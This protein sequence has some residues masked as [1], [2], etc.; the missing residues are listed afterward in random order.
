[1]CG[2][3]SLR[4]AVAGSSSR[5]CTASACTCQAPTGSSSTDGPLGS[6]TW[7]PEARNAGSHS[8]RWR[9]TSRAVHSGTGAGTSHSCVPRT[10]S[11]NTPAS[12]AWRSAGRSEMAIE[13]HPL[14]FGV[15]LV[16]ADFHAGPQPCV[17]ALEAVDQRLRAQPA[18]AAAQV[19]EAE[20]LQRDAVGFALEGEGL[21]D[22]LRPYV[23]EAPAEPVLPA[24]A[25]HRAVAPAA[26]GPG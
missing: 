24:V 25:A 19:V 1:M 15:T 3:V 2:L 12:C 11:V 22:P 13:K 14:Q 16:D 4:S 26:A 21:H 17:P 23:V 18:A 20:R 6:S 8:T 7:A 5:A 10:R 9:T